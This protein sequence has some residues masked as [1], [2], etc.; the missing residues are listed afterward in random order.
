MIRAWKD[1]LTGTEASTESMAQLTTGIQVELAQQAHEVGLPLYTGA[2]DG[3]DGRLPVTFVT[4]SILRV[5]HLIEAAPKF[6]VYTQS[7]AA[8]K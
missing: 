3:L 8:T 4:L 2:Q 1:S 7:T 5:K 6:P